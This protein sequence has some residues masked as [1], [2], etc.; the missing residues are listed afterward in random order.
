MDPELTKTL[1]DY[2][3][4]SGCADIMMHTME[5]YFTTEQHVELSDELAEGLMRTVKTFVP[6]ALANPKSYPARANL[7][8]AGAKSHDGLTASSRRRLCLPRHRARDWRHV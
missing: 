1:P 5:R 2:Q 6:E 7:L 3:T 8:L 4:E